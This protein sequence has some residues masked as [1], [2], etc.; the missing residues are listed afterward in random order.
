LFLGRL[1]PAAACALLT[2]AIFGPHGGIPAGPALPGIMA[3][4]INDTAFA[5]DGYANKQNCWAAVTF[6]ST[7]HSG[8][9]SI[10][11]SFRH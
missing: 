11:D 7:N 3:S 9:G 2:L 4:N 8:L 6:D 5:R 10:M 1:V